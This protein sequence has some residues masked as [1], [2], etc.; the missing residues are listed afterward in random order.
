MENI[1]L[2]A[3]HKNIKIVDFGLSNTYD[4]D[5]ILQT[6]CGSAEYAA[7][8]LF[9]AGQNYGPEVD[10]WSMGICMFAM[11][12]GRL[13]FT[14]PHSE[15]RRL[16]LLQQIQFGLGSRHDAD[17]QNLSTDC[18]E[19]LRACIES[20]PEL[21]IPLLD[22][23]LHPWLTNR[24]E[25]PF[26]PYKQLAKDNDVNSNAIQQMSEYFKLPVQQI[27][28]RVHDYSLDEYSAIYNILVDDLLKKKGL[29]DS[30]HTLKKPTTHHTP[31][32]LPESPKYN[33][34]EDTNE[35]VQVIPRPTTP[36]VVG[37][38]KYTNHTPTK[39][40]IDNLDFELAVLNNNCPETLSRRP[41][42]AICPPTGI[43]T[44]PIGNAT[45]VNSIIARS[46]NKNSKHYQRPRTTATCQP[47]KS[48]I[49]KNTGHLGNTRKYI[50]EHSTP[51]K[52]DTKKPATKTQKKV[53]PKPEATLAMLAVVD[54]ADADQKAIKKQPDNKPSTTFKHQNEIFENATPS[55]IR[56]SFT[57]HFRTKTP[58][59]TNKKYVQFS[60]D[61][62][63]PKNEAI[64]S[65]EMSVIYMNKTFKHGYQLSRTA[66]MYDPSE[67]TSRVSFNEFKPKLALKLKESR[68]ST[69]TRGSN[70]DDFDR[71]FASS[72]LSSSTLSSENVL[73]PPTR[74]LLQAP[75]V[76]IQPGTD[77]MSVSKQYVPVEKQNILQSPMP[78]RICWKKKRTSTKDKEKKDANMVKIIV[79]KNNVYHNIPENYIRVVSANPATCSARQIQHQ[80]PRK[81]NVL[82]N[83][84]NVVKQINMKKYNPTVD[85]VSNSCSSV[86]CKE[87]KKEELRSSGLKMFQLLKDATPCSRGETVN[88]C[89]E[90]QE[91]QYRQDDRAKQCYKDQL[92][93]KLKASSSPKISKQAANMLRTQSLITK[94]K[95]NIQP[96]QSRPRLKFTQA[97]IYTIVTKPPIL[98]TDDKK[99]VFEIKKTHIGNDETKAYVGEKNQSVTFGF[100]L[101]RKISNAFKEGHVIS[102]MKKTPDSLALINS[103]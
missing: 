45:T 10:I 62:N 38:V 81:A 59:I 54:M 69:S 72:R 49:P 101:E 48:P 27:S 78:Q 43:N 18:Q 58:D 56:P 86:S 102:N 100:A 34:V 91:T 31:V 40:P 88:M 30:D 29:F 89:F 87:C 77:K 11:V 93:S 12:T 33:E 52:R 97:D 51:A 32:K 66:T 92:P 83:S 75:K 85:H 28:Q 50:W 4:S 39:Q 47:S 55:V 2:D 67:N 7:P 71:D 42:T 98:K 68:A 36:A 64:R 19:L 37:L 1:M 95:G 94:A 57:N 79:S 73:R 15:N 41:R 103:V 60:K 63:L 20:N 65:N 6:H 53:C 9:I 8:E 25:E 23:Q 74:L 22:V 14:T 90:K 99:K 16:H 44:K 24:D 46:Y 3:K 26:T 5:Q 84:P 70:V 13:P 61:A 35:D 17:L 82:T 21:R 96:P 76:S 80:P